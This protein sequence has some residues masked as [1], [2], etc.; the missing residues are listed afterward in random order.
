MNEMDLDERLQIDPSSVEEK[1]VEFLRSYLEERDIE[2]LILLFR[3]DVESLVNVKLASAAVGAE[4]ISL[5]VTQGRFSSR[6]PTRE[7]DTELIKQYL[8]LPNESLV[9][10]NIEKIIRDIGR[11][12][13]EKTGMMVARSATDSLPILNYNLSYI[14]FKSMARDDFEL[15]TFSPPSKR[16]GTKREKFIRQSIAHYKSRIR[17][18]M[19]LSFLLAEIENK[20]YI[21]HVNKTE[22]LLGLFTKFGTYHAADFLP[23]AAL[24]KT[25]VVQLAEYLNLNKYLD[26]R[27]EKIP[28]SYR[29]FFDLSYRE[30]DRVLLR[31]EVGGYSME[32]IHQETGVHFDAIQK[33]RYYYDVSKYARAVPLIPEI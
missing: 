11:V 19:L 28:T 4:N 12:Y 2:G 16:P 23:L 27:V 3:D 5:I 29:F 15:E 21:G 14:L 25:Q 7:R 8:N 22:W 33:I 17:L 24:Y 30:V 31:L 13:S 9:F 26:E 32:E 10:I 18:N 1:I 20:S 6:K